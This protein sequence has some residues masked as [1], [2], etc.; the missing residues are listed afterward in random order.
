MRRRRIFTSSFIV[1]TLVLSL[2]FEA[3][4]LPDNAAD[5][6]ETENTVSLK[7]SKLKKAKADSKIVFNEKKLSKKGF[8][9][10]GK[11][12][13]EVYDFI[14]VPAKVFAKKAGISY[15]VKKDKVTL[16]KD[17]IKVVFTI[18]KTSY[19][20]KTADGKLTDNYVK[21]VKKNDIL[22]VPLDVFVGL[23]ENSGGSVAWH[24]EGK[25]ICFDILEDERYQISG[26]WKYTET[27]EIPKAVDSYFES[28]N[29]DS[30]NDVQIV[31]LICVGEQLVAGKNYALVCRIITPDGKE[32]F[33]SAVVYVDLQG[34]VSLTDYGTTGI[35]THFN[36]LS[37]GWSAPSE[38]EIDDNIKA[39]FTKAMGE[40]VGVDYKPIAVLGQQVVAGMNY[41]VFCSAKGVYPG[42]EETFALVYV[43]VGF[44]GSAQLNDIAEFTIKQVEVP[45]TDPEPV[46][47]LG[48]D[49]YMCLSGNFYEVYTP[50]ALKEFTKEE[51]LPDG[52]VNTYVACIGKDMVID[53]EISTLGQVMVARNVTVTIEKDALLQAEIVVMGGAQI[54]VK[55]GG[56]LWTTQAGED[57][58]RNNGSIII[59]KGGE[60]KSMFGGTIN[61]N[62]SGKLTIDGEFYCGCNLFEGVTSIW[63]KNFGEV[64]GNG[65][66]FVYA[67]NEGID[68]EKCSAEVKK[69]LGDKTEITV[70]ISE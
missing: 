23:I 58:M 62:E 34:N 5:A 67:T 36:G 32:E 51:E 17:G 49:E 10:T 54:I 55:D 22:Y 21:S 45:K 61:N 11:R 14:Y 40:L 46:R 56:R 68:L 41:C 48:P 6:A 8:V 63:F 33:G 9:V 1:L 26:G 31:P 65:K 3:F 69:M 39:A 47:E 66:I 44:D 12:E 28:Y 13:G 57:A 18:G 25:K 50:A 19:T 59:E 43:Y 38:F 37:G 70:G 35:E 15:K 24:V 27:L 42:A 60:L 30:K 4:L 16:T 53:F 64:N 7:A 20:L 52:S 2:V 29:K